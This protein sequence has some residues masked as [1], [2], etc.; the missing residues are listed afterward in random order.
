LIAEFSKHE[1]TLTSSARSL[2]E[3]LDDY[4]KID[5]ILERLWQY[6]FLG[7]SLD[8]SDNSFQSLQAKVR[9]LINSASAASW[10]LR[11][12]ILK[13]DEKLIDGWFSECAELSVYRRMIDKIVRN[14]PYSLSDDCE[15]MLSGIEDCFGSHSQIRSVFSNSDIRFGKIKGEN[16]E[17]LE[18]T[19]S[20]YVSTLM[21]HDRRVR[22]SAF[23]T[24]YKTYDQFKN[25]YAALFDA[26]IKEKTT[27]SRARG[28]KNS[29]TASTFSDEMTPEIYNN[30]IESAVRGLPV[31]Y[32]YYELKRKVLGVKELHMYDLY[33]TLI[34]SVDRK[35]SYDEA[36]N[37]VLK[38]T[39]IFGKEYHDAISDGLINKHWADVY[40]TRGKRSGAFSSGAPGTEPYILL[41]YNDSFDDVSTL[42]HE[43]G[44]SMHTW[45]STKYNEPHNSSYTL[46]VA[47]VASTVNELLLAHRKLRESETAEEKMYILNNIMETYKATLFRQA[48]FAEF[49]RDMHALSETGEP[50]TAELISDN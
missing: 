9:S 5:G 35:Y 36:V 1:T 22:R 11:P 28:F 39:E 14:K 6:A 26:R 21:S 41:N 19:D 37:E 20:N 10:F 43:A 29:L 38:T 13:L 12:Y 49:E 46:F 40:P 33:P 27:L 15:L 3:A 50:L 48:M 44:H 30:L 23:R 8:T 24:I 4:V 25:T 7:Y 16:G 18:I 32:R 31:L 47:E 45:F 42:A 2:C 17:M 34:A